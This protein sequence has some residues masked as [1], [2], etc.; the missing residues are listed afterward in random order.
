MRNVRHALVT[1]PGKQR[2]HTDMSELSQA[3]RGALARKLMRWMGG[4]CDQGEAHLLPTA[5]V[6][7]RRRRQYE[8]KYD[9]Q[10][11]LN[12]G[13]SAG[14]CGWNGSSGKSSADQEDAENNGRYRENQGEMVK[15]KRKRG[16][17]GL[18][19]SIN[20]LKRLP[21]GADTRK[22]RHDRDPSTLQMGTE[23][24]DC[25]NMYN[26]GSGCDVTMWPGLETKHLGR[27]SGTNRC[28]YNCA[29]ARFDSGKLCP[30]GTTLRRNVKLS[31]SGTSTERTEI[32]INRRKRRESLV[33]T[34]VGEKAMFGDRVRKS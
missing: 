3:M 12:A 27:C 23:S 9:H 13:G 4:F 16:R 25:G 15:E 34:E 28:W 5:K 29:A 7:Q 8:H 32:K 31:L 17:Y 21:N 33:H 22:L 20:T 1:N 11:D 19:C 24:R 14:K 30:D 2:E 18:D 6:A 10:D 26:A